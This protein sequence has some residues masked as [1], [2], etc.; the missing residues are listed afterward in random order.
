MG[1]HTA[2]GAVFVDETGRRAAVVGIA[3][4][5]AAVLLVGTIGVLMLS[6]V[7]KVPLPGI[8]PPAALPSAEHAL[9]RQ[10]RHTTPPA[11]RASTTPTSTVP[12]PS[13]PAATAQPAVASP[14]S[15]AAPSAAPSAVPSATPTP[16]HGS[17]THTALPTK[18]HGKPTALPTHR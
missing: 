8:S 9:P 13:T 1:R 15:T 10:P 6:V 3:M 16:A 12:Q 14:H 7:G 4:R 5:I 2:T 11:S 17:S 18:A